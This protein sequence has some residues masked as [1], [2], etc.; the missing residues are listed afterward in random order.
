MLSLPDLLS[1]TVAVETTSGAECGSVVG[2]LQRSLYA[3]TVHTI[4]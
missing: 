4:T 3:E 2:Q 1:L